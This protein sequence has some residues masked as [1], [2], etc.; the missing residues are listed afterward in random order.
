MKVI[1]IAALAFAAAGCSN[2]PVTTAVVGGM[3]I[4]MG[5]EY[6]QEP[7]SMPSVS[8]IYD[9]RGGAAA[10]SMAPDRKVVE[11]DCSQPIDFSAG[12]LRCK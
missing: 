9:W 10:P 11:Q 12:N 4:Y 1:A 2:Q 8:D 5:V 6:S 3:L 7:R